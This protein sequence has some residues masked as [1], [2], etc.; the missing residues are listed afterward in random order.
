VVD[1]NHYGN[2]LIGLCVLS[3]TICIVQTVSPPSMGDVDYMMSTRERDI[4]GDK[5]SLVSFLMDPDAQYPLTVGGLIQTGCQL[6]KL[7]LC[8]PNIL[9]E[10][11]CDLRFALISQLTNIKVNYFL[12]SDL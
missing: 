5:L 8:S 11:G 1:P 2:S 7:I 3:K 12:A 4:D 10:T 6:N 9:H